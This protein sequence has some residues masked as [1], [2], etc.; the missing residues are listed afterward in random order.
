MA[1]GSSLKQIFWA[2][3]IN[4]QHFPST[5]ALPIVAVNT[6]CN[7]LNSVLAILAFSS[8]AAKSSFPQPQLIAGAA[9][10]IP[11]M[12]VDAY[13]EVQRKV[14]KANPRNKGKCYTG[15]L[16]SLARHINYTGFIL[17][18]GS[19]TMASGGWIPGILMTGWFFQDFGRRAIPILDQY[20]TTRYGSQWDAFKQQT[21]SK[22][23]PRIW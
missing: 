1:A 18:R 17:W 2:V 16:W 20:C 22:L 13:S 4:E 23:I 7:S 21:P 9:I 5:T 12:L 14:F 8:P 6:V 15:G 3:Y 10:Y 19:Y 11:A